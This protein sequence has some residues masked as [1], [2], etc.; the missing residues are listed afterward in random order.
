MVNTFL[1]ARNKFMPLRQPELSYRAS[2]PFTKS[3]E[4]IQ[5]LKEAGDSPYICQNELDKACSQDD[6]P[7]GDFKYL[8]RRTASDK[9]VRDK[10]FN[11][12]KNPKYDEHQRGLFLIKILLVA[13]LKMRIFH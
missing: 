1:L 5:K 9:I 8:T 2:G 4:R 12:A 7:Y 11:I 6:I 13:V 10:A 3:K